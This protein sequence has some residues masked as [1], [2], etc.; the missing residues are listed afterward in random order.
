[1]RGYQGRFDEA[2]KLT[3]EAAEL[4]RSLFGPDDPMTLRATHSWGVDLR[5]CGRFR[6]ALP[7]DEENARQREVLF[8]ATS[9]FT[10]NSLNA[11]AIDMRE[12]GD[13]P[14]AREFLEDVYRRSRGAM[15][16]E[17]PLTLR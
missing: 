5:L 13:Y 2:R 15:G 9:F 16:E 14:G 7:L 12:S 17:H 6:E 8:G 4:A 3:E 11:L 1:A 10:L